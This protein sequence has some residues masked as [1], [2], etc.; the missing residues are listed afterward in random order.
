MSKQ[1]IQAASLTTYNNTYEQLA[2]AC[3]HQQADE[4]LALEAVALRRNI[5]VVLSTLTTRERE[6]LILR[7]GLEGER[8]H[9]LEEIG[10]KYGVTRERLRLIEEKALRKL[11]T[12]TRIRYLVD[13]A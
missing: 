9:T 5:H 10:T 6:F 11:R 2:K 8:V 12:P 4:N 7:F 3:D 13:F 1:A